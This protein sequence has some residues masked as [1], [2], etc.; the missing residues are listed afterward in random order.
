MVLVNEVPGQDFAFSGNLRPYGEIA[1][2]EGPYDTVVCY[3][4][5]DGVGEEE[6]HDRLVRVLSLLKKHG[7]FYLAAENRFGLSF[8]AGVNPGKQGLY[9]GLEQGLY[10]SRQELL[11]EAKECGLDEVRLLYP[12]PDY[13]RCISVY[14]DDHL[15]GKGDIRN[16]TAAL[17]EERYVVFDEEKAFDHAGKAFPDIANSFLLE[18]RKAK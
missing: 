16:L 8:L 18:G 14:S 11:S 6:R 9:E 7:R 4:I 13:R 12:V 15:P 3:G 2:I 17:G 10:Y 1:S 5:F